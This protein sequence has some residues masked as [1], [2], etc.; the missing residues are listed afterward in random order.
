MPETYGPVILQAHAKRLRYE[1]K[2]WAIRAKADETQINLKVIGDKYL[3][4]PFR[5]II[6]EPI[7]LLV[8]L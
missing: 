7:L 6:Q 2:N 1:Q 4:K 3:L 5:M 8:T